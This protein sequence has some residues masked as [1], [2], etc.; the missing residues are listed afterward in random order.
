MIP[1]VLTPV[2]TGDLLMLRDEDYL[3]GHGDIWLRVLA[4]HDIRWVR[5]EPWIFLRGRTVWA[6]HATRR[7]R[8]L[9]V[10]S[11]AMRTRRRRGW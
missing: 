11:E 7:E 3:F 9:L 8:D 10:R 2:R 6:A 5:A 4:V 1:A